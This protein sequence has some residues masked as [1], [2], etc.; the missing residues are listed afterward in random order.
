MHETLYIAAAFP[1]YG[2]ERSA[3]NAW[4]ARGDT[5]SAGPT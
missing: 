4:T 3:E 1:N 2:L 5:T